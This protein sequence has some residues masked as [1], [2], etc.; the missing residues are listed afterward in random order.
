MEAISPVTAS[1]SVVAVRAGLAVEST[2]RSFVLGL[3]NESE[4]VRFKAK[5]IELLKETILKNAIGSAKFYRLLLNIFCLLPL[6]PYMLMAKG[7]Q[8]GPHLLQN[9]CQIYL[10]GLFL[11]PAGAGVGHRGRLRWSSNGYQTWA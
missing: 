7:K 3:N 9:L 2:L 11:P 4:M 6:Q 10:K 5:Q 1:G 8:R